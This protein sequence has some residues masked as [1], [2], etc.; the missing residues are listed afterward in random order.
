[1]GAVCDFAGVHGACNL[2]GQGIKSLRPTP[3]IMISGNSLQINI[4]M[5]KPPKQIKVAL[6][7]PM[8]QSKFK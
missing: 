3:A 4:A 8:E 2:L 1:M 7:T 5:W 6:G